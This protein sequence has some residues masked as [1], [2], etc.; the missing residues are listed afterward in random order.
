MKLTKYLAFILLTAI[1]ISGC[2][3]IKKTLMGGKEENTDEFLI[4]KK[5]PL[6][7][8]PNFNDLPEPQQEINEIQEE[9][10][11]IDLSSVLNSSKNEKK[12][13]KGKNNSLEKSISNILNNN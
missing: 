8:P 9:N 12:K 13:V 3:S 4:K 7:L 2:S 5:S 11:N 10:K 6:I 1:F